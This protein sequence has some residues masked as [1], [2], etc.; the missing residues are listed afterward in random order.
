M[1]YAE[2]DSTG[3]NIANSIEG[4][5]NANLISAAPDLLA[6]LERLVMYY[7]PSAQPHR[8]E[9]IAKIRDAKAAISKAK[10]E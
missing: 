4:E 7:E 1:V 5:A 2:A 10:G 3:K 9:E 6:E 8:H